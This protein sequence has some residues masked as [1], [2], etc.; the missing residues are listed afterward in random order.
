MLDA[1]DPSPALIRTMTWDVVAW[2]DAA[3]VV[4]TD[5]GRLAPGTATCCGSCS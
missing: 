4:L 5:Y 1:L 2:N 3:A